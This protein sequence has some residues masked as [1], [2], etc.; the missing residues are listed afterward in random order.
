MDITWLGLLANKM[1][2]GKQLDVAWHV[3]DLKASHVRLAML[4]EFR[5]QLND[6]FSK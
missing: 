5:Q 1:V 2:D 6:E 4:K 3:D